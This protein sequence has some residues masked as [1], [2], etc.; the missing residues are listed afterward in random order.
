MD[1]SQQMNSKADFPEYHPFDFHLLLLRT[2]H[3][4]NPLLHIKDGLSALFKAIS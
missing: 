3:I 4:R 1:N 2:Q